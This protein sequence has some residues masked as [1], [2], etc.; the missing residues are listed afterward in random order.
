MEVHHVPDTAVRERWAE[1]RDVVTRR[2]VRYAALVVDLGPEVF[3]YLRWG[4]VCA[5]R[6]SR[7]EGRGR[8]GKVNKYR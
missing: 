7:K 6:M 5:L 4:P 1:D 2:P 8:E 3:D